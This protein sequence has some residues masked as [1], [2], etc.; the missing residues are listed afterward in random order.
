MQMSNFDKSARY[1]Y[2]HLF[3]QTHCAAIAMKCWKSTT[4]KEK[5]TLY[6]ALRVLR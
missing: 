4:A 3:L 6:A 1:I 5:H 2:S